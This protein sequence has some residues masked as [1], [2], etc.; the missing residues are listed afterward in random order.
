MKLPLLLFFPV[1]ILALCAAGCDDSST[2]PEDPLVRAP[3]NLRAW[4]DSGSVGLTWDASPSQGQSNFG[5]YALVVRD[6]VADT[7]ASIAIPKATTSITVPKLINGVRYQFVL[8]AATAL[9]KKSIDSI[10]V[11]W[12]PAVRH[13]TDTAG[14]SI[15]VYAGT[16]SLPDGIDLHNSQGRSELLREE[17]AAFAERG[18]FFVYAASLASDLQLV[19]P[20]LSAVNPGLETQFSNVAP[21]AAESFDNAPATVSPASATY[22]LGSLSVTDDI[23]TKNRIVYGRLLRGNDR[24]YF[25]LLLKRSAAGSFIHGS[26]LDRCVLLDVSFQDVRNIPFSKR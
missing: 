8:W 4:S 16:S 20:H 14:D 10:T 3:S 6:K 5:S 18:D 23:V 17:S 15:R 12:S 7:T 1:L 13:I 21:V 9:G 26:G 25:R 11:E 24:Y 22:V 19:S 2:G